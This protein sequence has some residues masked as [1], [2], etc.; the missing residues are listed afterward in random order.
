MYS[1]KSKIS[2]TAECI[3]LLR[4]DPRRDLATSERAALASSD[5]LVGDLCLVAEGTDQWVDVSINTGKR[6]WGR[7]WDLIL[8]LKVVGG[9]LALVET[10]RLELLTLSLQRRCSAN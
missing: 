9:L 2:I 4:C 1:A 5:P 3:Q 7:S 6:P 10:R 8:Q